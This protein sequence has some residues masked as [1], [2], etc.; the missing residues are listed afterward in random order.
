MIEGNQS[1]PS[2]RVWWGGVV[3]NGDKFIIKTTVD[4]SGRVLPEASFRLYRGGPA[5]HLTG[6][7][8]ENKKSGSTVR[9]FLGRSASRSHHGAGEEILGRANVSSIIGEGG[10][11]SAFEKRVVTGGGCSS[12][13]GSERG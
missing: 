8:G 5:Q 13:L 3:G 1:A 9:G 12:S 4:I 2:W 11:G 7:G 10:G 6:A